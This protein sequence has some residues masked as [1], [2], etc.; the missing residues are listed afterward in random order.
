MLAIEE[1]TKPY[2]DVAIK[3]LVL[4]GVILPFLGLAEIEREVLFRPPS[5]NPPPS[6]NMTHRALGMHPKLQY[7]GL[8]SCKLPW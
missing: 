8:G 3:D 4:P 7:W 5:R 1:N 6:F 2:T